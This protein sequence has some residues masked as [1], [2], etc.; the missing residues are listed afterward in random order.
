MMAHPTPYA[1]Q[2]AVPLPSEDEIRNVVGESYKPGYLNVTN[3][4]AGT[5]D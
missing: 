2:I 5:G 3:M 4:L 1:T